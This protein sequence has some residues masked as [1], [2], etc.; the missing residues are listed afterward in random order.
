MRQYSWPG[1]VR[2]LQSVIKNALLCATGP[3]LLPDF[4]P[5]DRWSAGVAVTARPS[6]TTAADAGRAEAAPEWERFIADRLQAGSENLYAD[7]Q[8]WTDR[9]L[10]ER[11]LRHT[12]GNQVHAAKLLGITRSTLRTKIRSLGIAIDQMLAESD[13]DS[14][15]KPPSD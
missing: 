10:L 5:T 11:V 12:G 2:E 6:G 9:M 14:G 3:V 4:L 7:W 15:Q 8:A 1:N 13:D